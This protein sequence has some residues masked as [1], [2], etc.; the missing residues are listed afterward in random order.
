MIERIMV[1]RGAGG[2]GSS[3]RSS[4]MRFGTEN[5][6]DHGLRFMIGGMGERLG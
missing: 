1:W 3:R 4:I 2:Y 6:A 5:S